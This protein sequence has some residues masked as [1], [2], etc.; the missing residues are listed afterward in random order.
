MHA[1]QTD[2]EPWEHA[3]AAAQAEPEG[4][5]RQGRRGT[6]TAL[7]AGSDAA[8]E[9]ARSFDY[10]FEDASAKTS[11]IGA[12]GTEEA[13]KTARVKDE[14]VTARPKRGGINGIAAGIIGGVIAL[15]G[16]GGLQFAGLLGAPGS[17]APVCRST[18]S[19]AKSHRSRPRSRA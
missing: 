17:G 9:R 14:T 3:D 1:D 12:G 18:A 4:R 5:R 6:G 2:L 19:M 11:G 15:V 13:Q 16:A 10:G 8:P 7:S